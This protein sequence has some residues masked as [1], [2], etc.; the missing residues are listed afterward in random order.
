[1]TEPSPSAS[2]MLHRAVDEAAA[3]LA[4]LCSRIDFREIDLDL[5][6]VMLGLL[7]RQYQLWAALALTPSS[8][9]VAAFPLLLRGLV[10]ALITLAWIARNPESAQRFK[11]YSAGRLKLLAEHW[12]SGSDPEQKWQTMYAEQLA[13]LADEEKWLHLLPVELGSWNGKDI[14]SMA[15][16]ADLKEL[17][18][19]AYSPLSA[20]AHAEWMVL[21]R[22]FLRRCEEASH[23]THWL[24]MF[25]RPF[26]MTGVP[27]VATG[28]FL[29]SV[30]EALG[31][32]KLARDESFWDRLPSAVAEAS[33]RI[34]IE[35]ESREKGG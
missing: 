2:E 15:I 31:A 29:M 10:D 12:R 22:L 9:T 23:K 32:L 34:A 27:E 6:D 18:D 20:E 11:L 8:W 13:E 19:L 28:Y 4:R 14:R 30:E 24:P 21:R 5:A 26:L 1:M 35:A 7:A 25:R 16:D 17:Y 33:Q 3:E